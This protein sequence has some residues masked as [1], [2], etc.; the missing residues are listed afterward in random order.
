VVS[1]TRHDRPIARH[2]ATLDVRSTCVPLA[3]GMVSAQANCSLDEIALAVVERRLR[4]R[5]SQPTPI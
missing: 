4:F 2:F 3:A 5:D 1:S